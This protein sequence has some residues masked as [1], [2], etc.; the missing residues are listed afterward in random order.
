MLLALTPLW[1]AC[2]PDCPPCRPLMPPAVYLQEVPEPQFQGRANRDLAAWALDL[3]AA[4]RQSNSDKAALRGW[5]DEL[6]R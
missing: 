5:Y 3:K 6:S 2:A 1:S 4:L